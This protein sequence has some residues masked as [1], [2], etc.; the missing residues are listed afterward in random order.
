[1][2]QTLKTHSAL[3]K[4]VELKENITDEELWPIIKKSRALLFPSFVEGWGMPLVEA[5][6]L[7]VPAICSD[8]P[9]LKE[10]G[11]EMAE[12]CS[13]MNGEVWKEKILEFAHHPEKS[14]AKQLLR[15]EKFKAPTWEGHFKKLE[16]IIEQL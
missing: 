1:M 10:A 16:A 5:L 11:Q 13:P 9:A 14:R 8:I 2:E 12:Y 6:S 3:Q 7:Q 15:L 4:V